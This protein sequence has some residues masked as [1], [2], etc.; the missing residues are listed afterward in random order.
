M[1]EV[2]IIGAGLAGCEA[3]WYLANRCIKVKLYEMKPSKKTP[4]H[5]MDTFAELVCSNSLRSDRIENAVGLLK[6]EL[7]ELGSLIMEAADSTK[8]PA[9]GALAVDR[10]NFSSYV[11]KKIREHENIEV[12]EKEIEKIPDDEYIILATGPLTT[13]SL[14][15]DLMDKYCKTTMNFYD[16]VAPI[17][18]V[19]SINMDIAFKGSRYDRGDDYINCPMNKSEYDE[20]YQALI[21]AQTSEVKGFEES[22]VFEGCMPIESM[23]KRGPETM[24]YGPLK[25]V[26]MVDPRTGKRPYA[27]VQLRQDNAAATLYNL[28]GF[29]TRLKVFEQKKVFSMIP[30]LENATF[31]RYGVMHRNTYINSPKLLDES[32]QLTLRKG[33][34]IAGQV[35]GVEGYIESTASG[36][37]AAMNMA[38]VIMGDKSYEADDTTMLGAIIKYTTNPATDV[39]KPMNANFGLIAPLKTRVRNKKD[40]AIAYSKRACENIIKY[41]N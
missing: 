6:Q 38:K 19:E 23:A 33:M 35:M 11:D 39:L 32:L 13:D 8:V 9:G 25:P 10:D 21:N 22:K 17:V 4:A 27:I 7:R 30:G 28:V 40:R 36:M 31:F 34:Y 29:Q 1:Q 20:F 5:S 3:A 2:T 14:A 24:A 15:K 37:W 18:D 26:G 16:A 12:I 41:K